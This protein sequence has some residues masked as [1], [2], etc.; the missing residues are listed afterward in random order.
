MNSIRPRSV[1]SP[2]PALPVPSETAVRPARS[3]RLR[4]GIAG[5][6]FLI[7]SGACQLLGAD[8]AEVERIEALLQLEEG[9]LVADVGA[10]DGDW[11]VALAEGVGTSG[12]VWATEV[13]EDL[14]ED[15]ERL[16][17]SRGLDNL[18][19]V[20]GDQETIGL[21]EA[22]CEAILIRM[23]YHHFQEPDLMRR[24][25]WRALKPG[26]L[27]AVL[28]IV[29]Q[30]H[31]RQLPDVPDRGG[32]GIPTEA[33]EREMVAS[34]FEVVSRHPRWN[35]DEERFAVLFRRPPSGP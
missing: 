16:A 21:P 6:A 28:D 22:C 8:P 14:V 20:L 2:R 9:S 19:A 27:V 33:L 12:R 1:D 18:T 26:G 7:L 35:D 3:E 10:G 13:K 25:L 15:I 31:W 34:G 23:V 24:E 32:H 17:E 5:A 30:T 11:A 4:A 29:P